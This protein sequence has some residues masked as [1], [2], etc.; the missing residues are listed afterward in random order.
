M[1]RRSSLVTAVAVGVLVAVLGSVATGVLG[2]VPRAVRALWWSITLPPNAVVAFEMDGCPP[3]WRR[4]ADSAGRVVLGVSEQPPAGEPVVGLRDRAGGASREL[5][6]IV[7]TSSSAISGS[8]GGE[9]AHITL[10]G[11]I[12]ETSGRVTVNMPPYIGLSYCTPD[13]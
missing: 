5:P 9:M 11:G 6:P 2:V 10:S 4:H 8:G 3:G 13:R 1:K 12:D 7:D